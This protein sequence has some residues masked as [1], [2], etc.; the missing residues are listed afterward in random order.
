VQS[1]SCGP[2]A[3]RRK[4]RR[5][6]LPPQGA[7]PRDTTPQ[8]PGT[9]SQ[10][11]AQVPVGVC[12]YSPP[13]G[14]NSVDTVTIRVPHLSKM[15][16]T[17]TTL[18]EIYATMPGSVDPAEPEEVQDPEPRRPQRRM[19]CFDL[20]PKRRRIQ[21]GGGGGDMLDEFSQA[22]GGIETPPR[23][24][25]TNKS[26]YSSGPTPSTLPKQALDT[27]HPYADPAVG[28]LS[29]PSPAQAPIPSPQIPTHTQR[30]PQQHQGV[31]DRLSGKPEGELA[32]RDVSRRGGSPPA[33]DPRARPLVPNE[34]APLPPPPPQPDLSL[35][36]LLTSLGWS[37]KT[38]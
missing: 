22:A 11:V 8:D 23:R 3:P 21:V 16:S 13:F 19:G 15:D 5:G 26:I 24:R 2:L 29:P 27:E 20:R 37:R 4:P 33:I 18:D 34:S 6:A 7:Q 9:A 1:T 12:C 38:S 25:E 17:A 28:S 31:H 10:Q 32:G 36:T 35:L 14:G 30:D